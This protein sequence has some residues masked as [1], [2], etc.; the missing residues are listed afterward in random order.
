[1]KETKEK[2]EAKIKSFNEVND[3]D[4]ARQNEKET[5]KRDL[6]EKGIT[7]VALIVTI[8]VLLILAGVAIRMAT[9]GSGVLGR[10]KNATNVYR[11]S[12]AQENSTL[13]SAETEV[14]KALNDYVNEVAISKDK[15]F[16]GYYA[17]INKDGVADGVIYADLAQGNTKGSK[18]VDDN[19]VYTISKITSGL[20]DYYISGT[21]S[22]VFGEKSI[23]SPKA[24]EGT[25]RFY[26]M[27]LK[28][29][30][31]SFNTTYLD[32]YNSAN[33]K[34]TDFDKQTSTAF[35]T[36]ATNTSNMYI[37]WKA[38]DYG[39]K[40]ACTQH[41]D[42]WEKIDAKYKDGWFIPSKE[43]LSAFSGELGITKAN[44]ANY[45][46]SDYLWTSSLQN[47]KCAYSANYKGG[48]MTVYDVNSYCYLRLSKKF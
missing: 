44:H 33:S 47:S 6:H 10:A 38:G 18:W 32:W 43:E 46:I 5:K 45:K 41:N 30:D 13:A 16:V 42:L 39:T 48:A 17:D 25:E 29:V 14:D 36:G 37:K 9:S 24:G 3:Y 19:G 4:N 7:L 8:I 20:K 15:S 2:Y 34:I 23:I 31:G 28:D 22:G 35:G 26:I 11:N 1:M 12:V 40:N 27:D 21:Y